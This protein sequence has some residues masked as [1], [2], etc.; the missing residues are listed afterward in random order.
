[1]A[2]SALPI[3]H[4]AGVPE[5]R[6]SP[7]G[8]IPPITAC[9]PSSFP[10]KFQDFF[11]ALTEDADDMPSL[12]EDKLIP[13]KTE[14]INPDFRPRLWS[15]RTFQRRSSEIEVRAHHASFTAGQGQSS[16]V[17]GP[18]SPNPSR[19]RSSSIAVARPTPD[20][21]R[22]LQAEAGPWGHL[23]PSPRSP[24]R[25]A[26]ISPGGLSSTSHLSPGASPGGPSPTSPAGPAS[27][28]RGPSHRQYRCRTSSMPAVPR[29]RP[30]LAEMKRSGINGAE[31][32]EGEDGVEYYRLRSFSITANGVFNLGDSLRS[33][34]SKSINS[35]TSSG[36]SC[37]SSR[38]ARHLSLASQLSGT[39]GEED[40]SNGRVATYKVGMLGASGVGKTALTAQFTTSEYIC[41]YD[42]SLDE[43]YGQK[44]VSVM[45][46]GQETELEII[47]HPAS[48]MSVESFCSTYNPDVYVVVYSVVDRRSL[49]M[50][51]ETLL[52]LWKSDYMASHGVI[53]VGNKVDLE[54]K[55]EVPLVVGRR[56]AN[57]CGCKFI[58][59]SS[60][61]AHH[62]DELL[63]GILAQVK[64]NPQR[65]RDQATRR[66]RSK[67]RRRMLK[68]LLGIKRK[69]KSCENLFIL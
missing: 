54:R 53:L 37:S 28:G 42:A 69:T 56:L 57:S 14:P 27:A 4:Q 40:D 19:R 43:E 35:V 7:G 12:L 21:H 52:Y 11:T 61:L 49:K 18:K 67:H 63:V 16:S 46:D 58:E 51:E 55:R 29:H 24:T 3:Y 1:M 13:R 36:T 44:T 60:G 65:D 6:R 68:H 23:S 32:A 5:A 10:D 20:L 39:E 66:K 25:T 22:F 50:A 62:V 2:T 48:E 9:P 38:D 34:R 33:R 15:K 59:T 45:V 17:D 31:E 64:L 26:A 41:A 30:M 8:V 47:D